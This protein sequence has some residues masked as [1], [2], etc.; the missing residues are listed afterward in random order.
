MQET[1]LAI[2]NGIQTAC[3]SEFLDTVM[4]ALTRICNHGEIWIVLALV[5]LLFKKTRRTGAVV[6]TALVLDLLCCNLLLKPLIARVRPCDVNTAVQLLVAHPTDWSFPSG[7]AASS[8]A[9][10][11]ALYASHSHLWIPAFI[12]ALL[13]CFSRLY[14]Y[15]HWPSDVLAGGLLG[16]LLGFAG[17]WVWQRIESAVDRRDWC[18]RPQ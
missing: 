3:R 15:V 1:E 17:R 11:S 13:I 10:T 4:P 16:I 14:L 2:L 8:F 5:L 18:V 7:H 12:L 9:A 6:A